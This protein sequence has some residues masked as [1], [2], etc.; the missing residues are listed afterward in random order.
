MLTSRIGAGI[1]TSVLRVTWRCPGRLLGPP[2]RPLPDDPTPRV[3]GEPGQ[4]RDLQARDWEIPDGN[5]CGKSNCLVLPANPAERDRVSGGGGGGEKGTSQ[6]NTAS[7]TRSGHSAGPGAFSALTCVHEVAR[8]DKGA[9]IT[10]LRHHVDLTRL[11]A[12][13]RAIRPKAA[14]GAA[15]V[16]GP[17]D[18]AVVLQLQNEQI[19]KEH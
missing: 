12:A 15:E 5:D 19:A 16:A 18:C 11:R 14:L 9:R 4:V 3:V 8:T 13:Y 7:K 1:S 17:T 2:V 6:G 10:A